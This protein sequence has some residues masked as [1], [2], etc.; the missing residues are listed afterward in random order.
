MIKCPLCRYE[1][2]I[3]NDCLY[4]G[5]DQDQVTYR[6]NCSNFHRKHG[7]LSLNELKYWFELERKRAIIE[8]DIFT[9]NHFSWIL[10]RLNGA[11]NELRDMIVLWHSE[12]ENEL[13]DLISEK[14]EELKE[15]IKD[16]KRVYCICKAR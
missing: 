13:K 3:S 8:E 10:E 5:C 15:R 12:T 2:D 9:E 14:Q 11:P 6:D 16:E 7:S 4:W 1:C